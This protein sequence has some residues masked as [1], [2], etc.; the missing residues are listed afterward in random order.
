MA[1]VT[2]R[3]VIRGAREH[4]LRNISLELPRDALIVFTGLSGS[5]KSSLAF[6]TIFAE[7]QRRYVESLSAYAR[8]FLGQMDKPDVDFIEGLSPAVSIDQKSTSRNP[9]STVGTITEVYD[10]LRLLYARAGRP[11]C[12]I[13]GEPISRQSPQQIVDR[14]LALEPGTRFQILAPVVR[15]RKGE[16]V[17]VFRQLAGGGFSRARVDGEIVSLTEPPTLDKKYKHSIDVVVDRLAV[18]PT[19][20]QRLTDS[21]ETA[22]GL[23]Q[24][25]SPSTSST[26]TPRTRCAS[27]ATR[28]R[29]ACPNGH[30]IAIEE[31]EP[32]QFSFNGPWG[33][34]P[35][36]SGLGT[37]M[38]VDPE[39]VVPDDEKTLAEGAI[40]PWASA[41]VADY[42]YRLI[43]SLAETLRL[44]YGRAVA[45]AAGRGEEAVAVRGA[46]PGAR[47]LPQPVRPG[48]QL[49]REVRGGR[50]LHRAPAR[51]GRDRHVPGALR[52]LHA[53][54]A[55]HRLPR[56]PAEADLAGGDDRRQEHRRGLE[57]VDR[58]CRR[59][60]GPPRA[61]RPRAA[62]RRAG[63]QG[64]QRA[65]EVPPRRRPRLP[66][67]QPADGEPV[68]R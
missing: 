25:V 22:L 4:N 3:L 38:E 41:Q 14:L 30:D 18:K 60:P 61:H 49:Q 31:L 59:V 26:S 43:A 12:P 27:G 68:R 64:D 45:L 46:G 1:D 44:P 5:G 40:A 52:R 2:D 36:C 8:Q 23:A 32:R 6:D 29:L 62:D 16:Y 13:C 34:C 50:L 51:R 28:R 53:R 65:A 67:A 17:D 20:K 66:V 55:L 42:F 15:G 33:A 10:Y 21:V 9:R 56:R 11:H 24:G 63:A 48:A 37:R 39:L 7:G 54:G 57:P 58:R 19:V 35:V 47:P